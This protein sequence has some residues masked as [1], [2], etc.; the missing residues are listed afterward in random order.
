MVESVHGMHL[1]THGDGRHYYRPFL[2]F[3]YR[4][5]DIM[6]QIANAKMK[7]CFREVATVTEVAT[8]VGTT[9]RNIR[10]R[11]ERGTLECEDGGAQKRPLYL[12]LKNSV[13]SAY[14]I[15]PEEFDQKLDKLRKGKYN[16]DK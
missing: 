9:P 2:F 15:S 6:N 12:I 16:M 8:I 11:C 10:D 3:F 14:K 5:S 1:S 4:K 13:C 7:T